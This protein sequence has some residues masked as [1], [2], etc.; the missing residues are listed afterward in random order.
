V[1]QQLKGFGQTT[2]SI[3][4]SSFAHKGLAHPGDRSA[5]NGNLAANGELIRVPVR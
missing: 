2:T 1:I 3:V 5:E 4:L